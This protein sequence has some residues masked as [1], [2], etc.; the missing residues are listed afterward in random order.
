MFK[1]QSFLQIPVFR[2]SI[3]P[4]KWVCVMRREK[5]HT[6]SSS[7]APSL[8]E[9]LA[10]IYFHEENSLEKWIRKHPCQHTQPAC[11]LRLLPPFR[12]SIYSS[13]ISSS[14]LSKTSL[15]KEG[16]FQLARKNFLEGQP[17]YGPFE[18]ERSK[19]PKKCYVKRD[20]QRSHSTWRDLGLQNLEAGKL[21]NT[22]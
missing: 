11:T 14:G 5:A 2:A 18:Q 3:L 9:T 22:F 7:K 17:W 15:P 20:P 6:S 8:A 4:G 21:L 12:F 1:R 16:R 19:V 10:Y 13:S